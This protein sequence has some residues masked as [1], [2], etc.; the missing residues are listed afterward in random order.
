[1]TLKRISAHE[2]KQNTPLCEP[3]IIKML[4]KLISTHSWLK[5]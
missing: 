5:G 3:K 1:M 2:L 4:R